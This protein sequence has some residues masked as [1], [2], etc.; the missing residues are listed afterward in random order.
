MRR[1]AALLFILKFSKIPLNLF[2][3][4]LTAKYFG[5]SPE[6]DIWL[7]CFSAM[8][9]IDAALWGPINETYRTK[10]I[11]IKEQEN[12]HFAIKY[13]QSLLTYF[14][15]FTLLLIFLIIQFPD[16]FI[17]VM[18]SSF[19]G[20]SILVMKKM[21]LL[22]AP[23]L[24][25]NQ[26]M[27]I[28]TSILN[29]YDVFYIPEI[30]SFLSTILN[31]ILL[32]LLVNDF[33]IYSLVLSYYVSTFVLIAFIVFYIYK[34]KIPLFTGKWNFR[35]E[36]FKIFF[37]FA[38]PFFLPYF[39]G[40][41]NLIVEKIFAGKLGVG[42]IS[43]LDFANKVPFLMN[44]LLVSV[45]SS[46]LVPQLAKYFIRK[47]RDNY[48]E[49]FRKMFQIGILMVG[50][51]IS[52]IFGCSSSITDFLF[53]KGTISTETLN[54]ISLLTILYSISLL[55]MY[56]YIIFGMAMLSSHQQKL[57]A[58]LGMCAQILV[59]LINTLSLQIK[60]VYIFPI[61][62]LVSHSI[63]AIFMYKKYPFI[64]TLKLSFFKYLILIIFLS[65]FM[66]LFE[67]N[68]N[69]KNNL[70]NIII[71]GGILF[72]VTN[73]LLFI[74]KFEEF[75]IIKNLVIKINKN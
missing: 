47:E 11:F 2:L 33:G 40:Q 70:L 3:L 22:V 48:N 68:I 15:I 58:V 65:C 37:L 8:T 63:L 32:Y 5:V 23:V 14:I 16:A 25:F 69:F 6:K 73:F 66:F 71:S 41:I 24:L 1:T 38:I 18:G 75:T 55:G 13:T 29:A 4:S 20:S 51:L 56:C 28:G 35:F 61:S 74:F 49:E 64:S 67:Q 43:S 7:L 53:N 34:R 50:L 36:G 42:I 26:L 30:S 72:F 46:V 17:Y 10:F 45:M 27:Q 21:L 12:D 62:I 31:I 59:A 9:F 54:E 57:Y 19:S 52:F 39:F 44:G 60:T